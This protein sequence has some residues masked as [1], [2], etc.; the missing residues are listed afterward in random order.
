MTQV[1]L[2][3]APTPWLLGQCAV[4]RAGYHARRMCSLLPP[5]VWFIAWIV[6]NARIEIWNHSKEELYDWC[7]AVK[8]SLNGYVWSATHIV[9]LSFSSHIGVAFSPVEGQLLLL[10]LI[11]P[12]EFLRAVRHKRSQALQ[13]TQAPWWMLLWQHTENIERACWSC[14]GPF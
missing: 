9:L 11:Q 6:L 10:F 13:A 5:N 12:D 3:R 1:P 4:N 8:E 7:V 14:A 2:G